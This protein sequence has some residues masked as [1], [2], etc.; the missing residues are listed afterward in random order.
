MASLHGAQERGQRRLVGRPSECEQRLSARREQDGRVARVRGE[1]GNDRTQGRQRRPRVASTPQREQ[2]V[3]LHAVAERFPPE[4]R[5][6]TVAP[7]IHDEVVARREQALDRKST[8]LN[9]SHTV[10]SYAVF[11]LKKKK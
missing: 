2:G 10:I 8:R 7:R 11:C 3:I 1:G 9:S 6:R 4:T 5:A